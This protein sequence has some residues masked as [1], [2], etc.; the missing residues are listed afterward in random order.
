MNII[1]HN[2][3]NYYGIREKI[4]SMPHIISSLVNPLGGAA[5]DLLTG[6]AKANQS[7]IATTGQLWQGTPISDFLV[8]K[9]HADNSP[10]PQKTPVVPPP[11]IPGVNY[12]PAQQTYTP[13]GPS[14]NNSNNPSGG[15][16][17][18]GPSD[19]Q[20]DQLLKIAKSGGLN[21]VQQTQLE[22]LLAQQRGAA[23]SAYEA[24]NRALNTA[25]DQTR[26]NLL[27]QIPQ[28]EGQRDRAVSDI[29]L[30]LSG[31]TSQVDTSRQNAQTNTD[32]QI[33]QAG[34]IAKTTQQQNRNILRALGII[35]SSAAGEMLS[36]PINEF[37]QQ[38]ATLNQALGQRL[39]ELDD[40]M[41]QKVAEANNQK[42][43]IIAQ[44]TDLYGKIQSDLRFNERQKNDAI[45]AA[46]ASLQQRL[47]DIQTN[48]FNFQQQVELQKQNFLQGIAQIQ[49]YNNPTASLDIIRNLGL[50]GMGNTNNSITAQIYSPDDERRREQGLSGA[51]I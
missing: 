49:A 30:G 6:A 4:D 19:S 20:L 42:N 35:N 10:P 28:L 27:S 51:F 46:T 11:G 45:K 9:A 44:F 13:A 41:N 39:G 36:K 5:W 32:T 40:F 14:N 26:E 8:G 1:A 16:G 33:R 50:S 48:V 29:E 15:G 34:S 24:E 37:G 12:T 22:Q 17:N 38:R 21:P 23:E 47:A 18:S 3:S 7:G 2:R 31:V 43:G 25:Y